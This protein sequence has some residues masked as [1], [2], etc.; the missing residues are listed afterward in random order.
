[1][2]QHKKAKTEDEDQNETVPSTHD[3]GQP[4]CSE[5]WV[6]CFAEQQQDAVGGVG[7]EAFSGALQSD[8]TMAA[9]TGKRK[10]EVA[11]CTTTTATT[12]TTTTTTTTNN[13]D[14][15]V[16]TNAQDP[17]A[18]LPPNQA[19][20][21]SSSLL[22]L[23]FKNMV[24]GQQLLA[25]DV[26]GVELSRQG[27]VTLLSFG[28][29]VDGRVHVFLVDVLHEDL[30]L[31]AA[32]IEFSKSLLEDDTIV[33]IVHDCRQV[34]SLPPS[35]L[36]SPCFLLITPSTHFVHCRLDRTVMLCFVQSLHRFV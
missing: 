18:R 19:T 12:T 15:I 11:V 36:P 35:S 2:L 16:E 1:M 3:D 23:Q 8:V 31:R 21:V 24:A 13:T 5:S 28:V 32:L 30:V 4:L 22:L 34:R 7:C 33:K 10:H 20:L 6:D 29:P 14:L 27:Q 17:F 25:F 9:I 26:E